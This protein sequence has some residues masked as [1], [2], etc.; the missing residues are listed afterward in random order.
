MFQKRKLWKKS[1]VHLKKAATEIHILYKRNQPG[2]KKHEPE[3]LMNIGIAY[4]QLDS[5]D[6]AL[7]FQNKTIDIC[8]MLR[9]SS[10]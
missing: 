1:L 3:I 4:M 10:S 9:Y 6:L 7:R 2:Y 5:L 8:K